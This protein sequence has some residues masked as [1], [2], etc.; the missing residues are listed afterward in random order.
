MRAAN[1]LMIAQG[2]EAVPVELLPGFEA[3][4]C[5]RDEPLDAIKQHEAAC[6][7]QLVQDVRAAG[8]ADPHVFDGF[9]YSFRIPQVSSEFDLLKVT[10]QTVLNIELKAVQVGEERVRR[11]LARNRYYLGPLGRRMFTF[12]FVLEPRV[13]YELRDDEAFVRVDAKR[14]V[15]VLQSLD[16]PYG[17]RLEALF[18]ASD[19]LVSPLND[20]RDFM[21]GRY[22]LTNHQ[23]Q[24]KANF[25]RACAAFEAGLAPT[26]ESEEYAHTQS[27]VPPAFLVYGSAGTGKTLLL[28][29]L[30]R[31]LGT[32][33]PAC[34][35]HCGVLA[36]GHHALNR[37]Q[38][39][40]VILSAKGVESVDFS[41][42]GAVL[43][44]EAQRMWP[45]QLQNVAQSA[46]RCGLPLF[47]SLDYRQM[48][49]LS[50]LA[51]G[52]EQRPD[53]EK[54]VRAT[55]AQLRTWRLSHKIRTNRDLVGFVGELFELRGHRGKVYTNHVKVAYAPDASCATSLVEAFCADGYEYIR[56]GVGTCPPVA[57][58]DCP[59]TNEVVG[60]E[61][62][63]VVMAVGPEF[64][65]GVDW[66]EAEAEVEADASARCS[67]ICREHVFQGVTRARSDL[68]LVVFDNPA[69]LA[70]LLNIMGV[71]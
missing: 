59:T 53:A 18:R 42:F 20:T 2:F 14:L 69:L 35:V 4:L 25:L 61:F 21:A 52:A 47:L 6:V 46:R 68:A 36:Q 43:V 16:T 45:A 50:E 13:L 48:L 19:Y 66:H 31:S 7:T 55:Y 1:L 22:F 30:A 10:A 56:L 29:D 37:A 64:C 34:V 63:R 62:D 28:Y 8:A 51:E 23:E 49:G 70:F 12:T 24:I 60:Q 71:V 5:E 40:F 41:A 11:Q 9:A 3:Q 17:G 32:E 57:L 44:D 38:N 26:G 39:R 27:N 65:V 58:E 54:T 15:D 33:R 67:A